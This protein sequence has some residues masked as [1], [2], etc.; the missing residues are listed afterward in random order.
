MYYIE[1][2]TKQWPGLSLAVLL[3]RTED[4]ASGA[5]DNGH[6]TGYEQEVGGE[7]VSPSNGGT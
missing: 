4:G 1:E 7:V 2:G 6:H 5:K 3:H